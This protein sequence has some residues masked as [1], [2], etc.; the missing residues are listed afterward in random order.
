MENT[1]EKGGWNDNIKVDFK[2]AVSDCAGGIEVAMLTKTSA[3]VSLENS[4]LTKSRFY[5]SAIMLK[6]ITFF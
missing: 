2:E 3:H 5:A 4:F 1:G 6:C